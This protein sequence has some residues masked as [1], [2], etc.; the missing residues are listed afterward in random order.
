M[1]KEKQLP[2][3]QKTIERKALK[4]IDVLL[5]LCNKE[6]MKIVK[7]KSEHS[8]IFKQSRIPVITSMS[9]E[10][11]VLH[12]TYIDVNN[13]F[14]HQ[15]IREIITQELLP[16]YTNNIIN[17]IINNIKETKSC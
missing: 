16:E 14:S 17:N 11:E 8:S 6:F 15:T 2:S 4:E 1:A 5:D 10:G 3:L 13:L 12:Y 9:D 7:M